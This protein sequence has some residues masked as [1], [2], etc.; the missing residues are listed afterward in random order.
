[1][2]RIV[3]LPVLAVLLLAG[4]GDDPPSACFAT[5]DHAKYSDGKITAMCG[6]AVRQVSKWGVTDKDSTL[7]AAAIRG[8]S[9][10][11]DERARA[12]KLGELWSMS[13]NSCRKA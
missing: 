5:A 9:V 1:M 2:N 7:L 12:H 13:M 11:A 8:K 3:A 10:A 6:C 4:C